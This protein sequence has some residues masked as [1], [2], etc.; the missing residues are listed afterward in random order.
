MSKT[1][2]AKSN[3][4]MGLALTTALATVALSGC[5]ANVAPPAQASTA[6]A[7]DALAKGNGDRAVT[8][9]EAAVLATPRDTAAR[10]LLGTAYIEAGRFQSAATTLAEAVALGDSSSGTLTRL[11]LAQ[12]AAGQQAAALATLSRHMDALDPADYGLAIALAGR[13]QEAVH[14]LGNLLRN[15]TNT[16]KVR[17]NLA[18][19]LALQGDWRNARIMAAED[20]PADKLGDTMSKWAVLS[21]PE[22]F[23]R[24]IADLLSVKMVQDP[25]QPS[26]LALHNFDSVEQLAAENL[27]P[28]GP[29]APAPS[30]DFASS[31]GNG[32]LPPVSQAP[33]SQADRP[34]LAMSTP[35]QRTVPSS[36][37]AE[38]ISAA[39]PDARFVSREVVQGIP[40]RTRSVTPVA[41]P[42]AQPKAPA[43]RPALAMASGDY[44]VQLGSY[45]SMSDAQTAWK[46]FLKRHPEI[47]GAEKVIT[48][49]NVK[50][51]IYYRV[52]AGGFAKSSAQGLC[53]S[54]KSGGAGCIAYAASNP[55]PG[56]IDNNVRVATR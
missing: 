18:Y 6:K 2:T 42:V 4:M 3:R 12:I 11:A 56:T 38:A 16:M 40:A 52:A 21:A 36:A 5:T 49:A 43:A 33:V 1:I 41:R 20:V 7:Q 30:R 47:D 39:S 15:G 37:S 25:G 48:K 32:E 26:M 28:N 24:R 29:A 34:A 51:K 14:V 35:A 17:Q 46:V 53:Q 13:P 19:S 23:Q 9:A 31:F 45:F 10:T 22:M 8:H 50:G 54:V 27:V 44:R 55:L